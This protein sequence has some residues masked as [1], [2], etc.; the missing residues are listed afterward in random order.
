MKAD[1]D[2]DPVKGVDPLDAPR[3]AVTL[4]SVSLPSTDRS[5][6]LDAVGEDYCRRVAESGRAR[7]RRW[8]W[9]QTLHFL[10][11][12]PVVRMSEKRRRSSGSSG[13]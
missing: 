4:L 3:L 8:Y 9:G 5:E 6:V 10:V 2:R 7:A 11:R 13:Q 1:S 12:M